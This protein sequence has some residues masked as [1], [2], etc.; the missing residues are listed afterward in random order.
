MAREYA[1]MRYWVYINKT[2]LGP[3]YKDHLEKITDFRRDTPVC[4]EDAEGNEGDWHPAHEVTELSGFIPSGAAE[5]HTA[6]TAL[7]GGAA[8][9]MPPGS[10]EKLPES[11]RHGAEPYLLAGQQKI[12]ALQKTVK[13]LR[14]RLLKKD[15]DTIA[16]RKKVLDAQGR[17][18]DE[19]SAKDALKAKL[20]SV[21]SELERLSK[22]EQVSAA[23]DKTIHDLQVEVDELRRVIDTYPHE[24]E[25]RIVKLEEQLA[26]QSQVTAE[27]RQELRQRAAILQTLRES[28]TGLQNRL[29]E[30]RF[31]LADM[32]ASLGEVT[33]LRTELQNARN[34]I[35]EAWTLESR[36]HQV[37]EGYE[38][39]Q[40]EFRKLLES[41]HQQREELQIKSD[42][43]VSVK[44]QLEEVQSMF[45]MVSENPTELKQVREQA[46]ASSELA[47]QVAT[48]EKVISELRDGLDTTSEKLDLSEK[49]LAESRLERDELR[50]SSRGDARQVEHLRGR[51][52]ELYNNL[53]DLGFRE[54]AQKA[55][56]EVAES[57]QSTPAGGDDFGGDLGGGM[58]G[59]LGGGMGGDLGGD[60]GGGMGGDLGGGLDDEGSNDSKPATAFE[61]L[62]TRLQEQER[63]IEKLRVK[64]EERDKHADNLRRKAEEEEERARKLETEMAD[65]KAERA[66]TADAAVEAIVTPPMPVSEPNE[67]TP[68]TVTVPVVEVEAPISEDPPVVDASPP[69]RES[70]PAMPESFRPSVPVPAAKTGLDL[71][72]PRIRLAAGGVVALV[73]V[74]GFLS[75]R[76][77][78]TPTVPIEPA[79]VVETPV[80]PSDP[81]KQ[82]RKIFARTA[83]SSGG[84]LMARIQTMLGTSGTMDEALSIR[85]FDGSEHLVEFRP[86]FTD[87]FTGGD[88]LYIFKVNIEAGTVAAGNDPARSLLGEPG[89]D[90]VSPPP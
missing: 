7:G 80:V 72:N 14:E 47:E 34:Q 16:L 69:P 85:K 60:L 70:S 15:H 2:I 30:G 65:G 82:V 40:D 28:A 56:P 76:S 36:L 81:L 6:P 25:R 63:D 10:H 54:I 3:Y 86:G 62:R 45:R 21:D 52:K 49:R 35:S 43:I 50:E 71:S 20:K 89:G 37:Q 64:L 18:N 4:R 11:L 88:L 19:E 73:A 84:M 17:G 33:R 32:S 46:E 53:I 59:D 41:Y 57:A 8:T 13:D 58:G 90:S 78:M 12:D 31:R 26:K 87:P 75:W 24:R 1:F 27:L 66:A 77:S 74:A 68:P 79:V 23:K 67:P 39:R 48:A 22:F 38:S 61:L 83:V 9:P 29:E 42:E 55:A 51:I 5:L 44:R